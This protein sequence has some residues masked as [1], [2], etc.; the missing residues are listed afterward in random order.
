MGGL[1]RDLLHGQHGYALATA[2]LVVY[3]RSLAC[4]SYG[5]DSLSHCDIE[6]FAKLMNNVW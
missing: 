6:L 5:L 1:P 3:A 4:H 2:D